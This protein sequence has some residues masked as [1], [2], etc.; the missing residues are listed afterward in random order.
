MISAKR[1]IRSR[2]IPA[3]I[4]LSERRDTSKIRLTKQ[5]KANKR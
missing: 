5:M 1:I 4:E 3:K 2:M